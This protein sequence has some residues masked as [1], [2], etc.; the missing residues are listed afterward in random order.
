MTYTDSSTEYIVFHY[1]FA[2][3]ILLFIQWCVVVNVVVMAHRYQEYLRLMTR[4]ITSTE[5]VRNILSV[6]TPNERHWANPHAGNR[7]LY[8]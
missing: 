6:G 3:T 1:L 2:F 4:Y 7:E 8:S 5:F